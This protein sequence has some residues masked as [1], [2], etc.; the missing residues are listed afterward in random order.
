MSRTTD[1][2]KVLWLSPVPHDARHGMKSFGTG[3]WIGRLREVVLAHANIELHICFVTVAEDAAAADG[4]HPIAVGTRLRRSMRNAFGETTKY[5]TMAL[6]RLLERIRPDLIHV[7]GTEGPLA[8]AL[9][10]CRQVPPFIV[11]LQGLMRP[12]AQ[13]PHGN[14]PYGELVRAQRLWDVLRGCPTLRLRQ[15]YTRRARDEKLILQSAALALGRTEF[16]RAYALAIAPTVPYA[17]SN[18]VLREPFYQATWLLTKCRRHT[19]FCCSRI[20]LQKGIPVLLEAFDLVAARYPEARLIIA[21]TFDASCES[22]IIR[23][24]V[25]SNDRSARIEFKGGLSGA[26]I[27][28][29]LLGAHVYVNPSFIENSSNSIGE[30]ALVGVPIVATHTGGTPT[31]VQDGETGLLA[32]VGCPYLL[33]MQICRIF[34]DDTLAIRLGAA[35]QVQARRRHEPAEIA[36]SLLAI[37]G[38]VSKGRK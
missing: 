19:L 37:Y 38:T 3:H 22:R 10:E 35:A 34:S 27:V 25:Q 16:D 11:S 33:A 12:C 6:D 5:L 23:R 2:L 28:G 17:R 20:S 9:I 31:M 18:E 30:A 32:S 24:M 15:I 13:N 21:G 4:V 1:R 36:S 26:Q 8:R 14:I 29:E 7:H